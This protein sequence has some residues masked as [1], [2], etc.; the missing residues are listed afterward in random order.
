MMDQLAWGRCIGAGTF[1]RVSFATHLP[2][3]TPCA[4]KTL[5]KS[6]ILRTGQLTHAKS[7]L[8]TLAAVS[9]PLIVSLLGWAQDPHAVHLVMTFAH[10]G[11]LF[12]HLRAC[13]RFDE[14]RARHC[15]S[16]IACA[17]FHLHSVHAVAYRDL[18]PENVLLDGRGHCVLADFGF[19]KRL[20]SETPKTYTLCGTPDYLAPE[21]ITRVGH[22]FAVD[23]WALGVLIYEMLVGYPPF[24]AES[25]METYALALKG[26][27]HVRFPIDAPSRTM[28]SPSSNARGSSIGSTKCSVRH[29]GHPG[30]SGLRDAL[31]LVR[32][33]L[34]A[35]AS[36]RF[37]ADDVA[38]HAWFA[39]VDWSK[40]ARG[41]AEPPWVPKK[42]VQECDAY[43]L[44][45]QTPAV[46]G[47]AFEPCRQMVGLSRD[48]L[49]LF[50]D[51]F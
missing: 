40:T 25:V 5:L 16:E 37:G 45:V 24:A 43:P 1:G 48:E 36:E 34:R 7:E 29:S 11:E 14:D 27:A 6:E 28:N 41:E 47:G 13:G 8:S 20:T 3:G 9:H 49:A 31:E 32:G 4:V 33:L 19:A 50:D 26:G 42:N 46:Q 18:K 23:W 22:E 12:T 30:H 35:N 38:S 10:G 17:L 51:F 39:G 44:E 15:A 21:I 2:T